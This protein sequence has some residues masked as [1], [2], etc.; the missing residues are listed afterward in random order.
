MKTSGS[1]IATRN[2]AA[3]HRARPL[4]SAPLAIFLA[5]I[6]WCTAMPAWADDDKRPAE[7][8]I[9]VVE[10]PE[11]LKEKINKIQLPG[12]HE[13][14]HPVQ[15][16]GKQPAPE[17]SS[18]ITGGQHHNPTPEHHPVNPSAA[19]HHDASEKPTNTRK[20]EDEIHH[21]ESKLPH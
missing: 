7:V 10:D 18:S 9:T 16:T 11:Q 8:T 6:G 21:G 4:P 1:P 15:Q 3:R 13:E 5:A 20:V 17:K 19:A 14:T 12:A 2:D